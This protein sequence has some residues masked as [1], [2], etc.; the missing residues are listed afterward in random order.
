MSVLRGFD[1]H[2]VFLII[3]KEIRDSLRNKWFVIYTLSLTLLAVLLVHI[4]Y[5]RGSLIEYRGY[6][7]T[8]ASLINLILLFIPLIALI[9]GSISLSGERE[10]GT[11]AYLLSHPV[12]KIEIFIGKYFGILISI[13][14]AVFLSF[15]LAGFLIYIK[16]TDESGVNYMLTA[17][18]SVLL[19]ASLLSMGFLISVFN[20]KVSKSI[21]IGILVWFVFLIVGDLGIIGASTV[22]NLG[23]KEVFY[24]TIVNPLEAYK[25][26]SILMLTPRFEVLGPPGIYALNNLGRTN[27]SILLILI[28]VAW[29]VFPM[30]FSMIHFYYLRREEI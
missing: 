13:T 14:V 7:R 25:I 12:S 28:Q 15:G 26:T 10:N 17:F 3:R 23:I 11:L 22:L 27:L 8:A 20:Y 18:L 16:G 29:V 1:F 30:L 4:G 9:T 19:A 6:G 24:L 2:N 5:T 21:S